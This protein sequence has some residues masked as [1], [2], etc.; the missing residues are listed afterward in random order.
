MKR[1]KLLRVGR[2]YSQL[3]QGGK[4]VTGEENH[5]GQQRAYSIIVLYNEQKYNSNI[6][7][8]VML[9]KKQDASNEKFAH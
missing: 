8:E 4:L 2:F 1:K 3:K 6:F 9:R 7:Q 5:L